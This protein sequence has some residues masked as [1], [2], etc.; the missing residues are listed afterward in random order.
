MTDYKFDVTV[1]G[2][3]IIGV[4]TAMRLAQ[5]YPKLKIGVVDRYDSTDEGKKPN[6]ID[7]KTVIVWSF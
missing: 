5:T 6:D 4:A 3:G 2:G 7:Y 1:I